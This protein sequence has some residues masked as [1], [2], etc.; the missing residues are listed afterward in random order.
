[1][2]ARLLAVAVALAVGVSAESSRAQRTARW[3]TPWGDPDLQGAWTNATTT[4][5]ERSD[6]SAKAVL[7][8]ADANAID[9]EFARTCAACKTWWDRGAT[10]ASRRTS[11]VVDP[12]DGRIPALTPEGRREAEARAE[13]R[14]GRGVA[15]SWED[16]PLQ[17][18][19]LLFH[20]VP[21][22]PTNYNNNYRIFQTRDV[23]AILYEMLHEVR[24]VPLDGRPHLA[25]AIS[26]W[27]GDSRGRW[28]GDTLVVDTTNFSDKVYSLRG[29]AAN[30][31]AFLGTGRT[32][33]VVERFTRTASDRIDYYFTIDDPATYTRPWTGWLPLL[34]L[35]GHLYE[36]ACHEGNSQ[37]SSILA[38]ARREEEAARS[39]R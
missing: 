22:L 4:P 8:D 9:A 29:A 18:R 31:P 3:T 25:P 11:I 34:P 38:G 1:M 32:M 17:E 26:R 10:V 6:A 37:M 16:R 33:R 5:L 28:E 35:D 2:K 27:M 7:S 15:D 19:C 36:Y 20:G 24:I 21:P 23:V 12:P 39:P 13:A 30:E 14:R